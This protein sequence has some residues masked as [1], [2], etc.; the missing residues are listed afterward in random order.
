MALDFSEYT[1]VIDDN[2]FEEVPVS[3]KEFLY[4]KAFMGLPPLS[5]L[6][7]KIIEIGS[8]IYNEPELIILH[9]TFE[10]S[11]RYREM[12]KQIINALGKGCSAPYTLVY[13][14]S[15]GC[16]DRLDSL[17]GPGFVNGISGTEPR[18]KS[19]YQ[20][21]G[22]MLRIKTSLGLE[23]DVYE[24]H[25]FPSYK[26]KK[27]YKRNINSLRYEENEAGLLISGDRLAVPLN[28][29]V[30][31]EVPLKQGEP[32]VLGILIGDETMPADHN[33]NFNVDFGENEKDSL[34]LFVN[35]I[36]DWGDSPKIIK[37]PKK[38]MF[39]VKGS[40]KSCPE[41]YKVIRK[42]GLWNKR[43]HTKDIPVA[44]WACPKE[45][46]REFIAGLWSS[47][48]TIYFKKT[49]PKGLWIAEYCTIS[50]DLAYQIQ[51]LLLRLGI[52][53]A[54][55]SRFPSYTYRG[56]KKQG[57][58]AYY[59]TLSGYDR[60]MPFAQQIPLMDYK[61][62]NINKAIEH[63]SRETKG[64]QWLRIDGDK[65]W[66]RITSVEKI[67]EGD[68]WTLTA[69]DTSIY[70][71]NC[72]LSFNSGKD[73]ISVITC[74]RIIYQL[75]CLKDPA[76]Y[77]GKPSGDAIDLV[78]MSVTAQS[79]SMI[80]FKSFKTRLKACP[81]FN[82][83]YHARAVDVEFDKGITLRSLNSE[84]SGQEGGNIFCAVLDELDEFA[85]EDAI[86]LYKASRASV[87]SRFP[88]NGKLITLSFPRSTES[89]V[90]KKYDEFVAEKIVIE[91][92]HT[93]KLNDELADGIEDNEFTIM[94]HED[95][96][97][98][99]KYSDVW[100]I[101]RPSWV[102][103]PTKSIE[104]YKMDF[105]SDPIDS[106][107]RF[108]ADPQDT[109]GKNQWYKDKSKIDATFSN[110]N[111]VLDDGTIRIKPVEDKQYYIHV[112]LALTQDNAAVA[113]AHVDSFKSFKI[114]STILDP[115]PHIVV[116]LVR[117]W[118]PGRD[119]AL[120]FSDIREF[121]VSLK[122][123]KFNIVRVTFDRWNSEGIIK[124]LNDIGINAEKLSVGRDQYSDFAM[125]MGENRLVG[126]DSELLKKEL[127]TLIV[128]DKGKIDHP[129]RTG[130][131][132]ADAVCGSIF[133]AIS[134]TDKEPNQIEIINWGDIAKQYRTIE[135]PEPANIIKPPMPT[136]I[137]DFLIDPIIL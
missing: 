122:R 130:N 97:L 124:A 42:H 2:P 20:G 79:A 46:L 53:A 9:G 113:M 55:R 98:S 48:G 43:A 29:E 114:G 26:K 86:K 74:L 38:K 106:L 126:P 23:I 6:Q 17:T 95:E 36:Q 22:K 120:D 51:K 49:G 34:N 84:T 127:R 30:I 66:D 62:D 89:I 63:K 57:Q 15:N 65:Y 128:T 70:T 31:N 131:D 117:Y 61:K 115:A 56:E 3:L 76:E 19:W 94:W 119:R 45:Q 64:S 75:L 88:K 85:E 50:K 77:F 39:M 93:F 102:V 54:I 104:D 8:E 41:L 27:F 37:H 14:A 129:G 82:G 101:R 118:K 12:K 105:Y 78:N 108:A 33:V 58:R 83:K 25:K 107:G 110:A 28:L 44:I 99:Y 92:T 134:L 72:L 133:N 100:C 10:G 4:S 87:T 68:Y 71:E 13:N 123:L 90:T 135:K 5:E 21:S 103:N 60:F 111:G 59:L 137:R 109:T 116:D 91:K 125:A 18:T 73:L 35:T 7:E 52:P 1:S 121:I 47:D 81:W 11:K 69:E 24:K 16:W 112:D 132:L 40:E 80:F 67:G 96:I 136:E 32:F